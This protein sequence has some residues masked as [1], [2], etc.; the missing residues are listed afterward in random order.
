MAFGLAKNEDRCSTQDLLVH[1]GQCGKPKMEWFLEKCYF[2]LK[3]C[4]DQNFY[5]EW[6]FD[7]YTVS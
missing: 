3:V 7:S 4:G 2:P 1:F 5:S 6:S